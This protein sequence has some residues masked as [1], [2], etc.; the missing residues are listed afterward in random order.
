[1]ANTLSADKEN[2]PDILCM[3]GASAALHVSQIPFLK[4]TGSVR[5]GRVGGELI[6]MPTHTELEESDLDLIVAGTRDAI[7]MIEG[8]AREMS[9]ESMVEAIMYAHQH[10]REV[11]DMIEQLP[12]DAGLEAKAPPA[13]VAANPLIEIFRQRFYNEF[14]ERKQT[15]GKHNRSD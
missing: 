1:M 4:P 3:I 2:D 11:V 13:P 15:T 14:R 10:I 12:K 6:V 9:E 8:F 5:I 7:T